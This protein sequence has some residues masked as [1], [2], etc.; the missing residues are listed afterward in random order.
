MKEKQEYIEEIN[1]ENHPQGISIEKKIE[2]SVC[3]IKTNEGNFG[4]GFFCLIP[5]PTKLNLLP[6]LITNNHILKEN[7]IRKGP[8]INFSMNND[9]FKSQ[10]FIDDLRKY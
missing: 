5:F 2:N 3:K 6:V 7:D 9:N 4:T 8:K 1:L 10:I